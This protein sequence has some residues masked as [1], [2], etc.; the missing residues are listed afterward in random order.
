MELLDEV[1][2]EFL[3]N[4]VI[5]QYLKN[6]T[7]DRHQINEGCQC[8]LYYLSRV[9]WKLLQNC[10][11]IWLKVSAM[12]VFIRYVLPAL[13]QNW[14]NSP[15]ASCLLLP[16]VFIAKGVLNTCSKFT[17]EHPFRTVISINLL[18]KFIEITLRHRFSPVNLMHILNLLHIF[19]HGLDS[20]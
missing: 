19:R 3:S 8:F 7:T 13:N 15:L 1:N 17:G 16:K 6:R 14:I 4:F 20:Q 5:Q 2:G 9:D 11:S 12:F 18:C 10:C